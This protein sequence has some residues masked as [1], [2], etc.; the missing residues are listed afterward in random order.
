VDLFVVFLFWIDIF[1]LSFISGKGG[2]IQSFDIR[3]TLFVIRT[4]YSSETAASSSGLFVSGSS[5]ASPTTMTENTKKKKLPY[6]VSIPGKLV[7]LRTAKEE[8][9]EWMQKILSD[10]E[11]MKHIAALDKDWTLEESK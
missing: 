4:N 11:T 10:R 9:D 2:L 7:V 6:E 1:Y 3:A 8:D 5:E